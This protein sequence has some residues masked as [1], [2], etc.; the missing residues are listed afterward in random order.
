[1]ARTA[2]AAMFGCSLTSRSVVDLGEAALHAEIRPEAVAPVA[3]RDA[4]FD[5]VDA[6][7]GPVLARA[8]GT[9]ND[10]DLEQLLISV[11]AVRAS[12]Q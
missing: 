10:A 5:G 6:V 1:M 2:A 12:S 4:L 8:P 9:G 3:V 7:P 11:D